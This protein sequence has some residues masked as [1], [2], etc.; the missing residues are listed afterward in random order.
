MLKNNLGYPRIGP[1]RKLKNATEKYWAGKITQKE[2]IETGSQIRVQNW[3]LQQEAGIDLIPSNDFSFYDHIL[4]MSLIT[5]NIPRRFAILFE[6]EVSELDIYFAMARGYQKDGLDIPAMEMT[7]WFNTNYHYIVPKF[8]RNQNFYLF[9]NKIIHEFEESKNILGRASKPVLIGP[10][11][12]LLL[13]KVKDKGLNRLDFLQYLLP[14]YFEILEKLVPQGLE[15]IQL[16]E[17]YLNMDLS[18]EEKAAYR[19][20]YNKFHERFPKVKFLVTT[21]FDALRENIP[22]ALSLSISALHID[23]IEAP[24]QLQEVL[25]KIPESLILSL[26]IIDGRNIWKNNYEKSVRLINKAIDKIGADRIMIAPSSSLL[27]VPVDLEGEDKLNPD[28]KSWLAFSKQKLNELSELYEIIN[29]DKDELLI[30]NQN[31]I[32]NRNSSSLVHNDFVRRKTEAAVANNLRRKS[33]FAIRQK[34]QKSQNRL[35]LFPTTTIGS[36]PQT[37][38]IRR[39]RSDLN[40]GELSSEEYARQIRNAIENAIKFQEK[41]GLDV[42]VHGEFER[43]DMVEYFGEML[44]GFA[45][46]QNGWV[47]SYG[48]RCV[49]P[50]IIY[51]DVNRTKDMTVDWI[52][53]AQPKT[54]KLVKGMLTGPVTILQWSFVRED[55]PASET[56][57]QIAAAVREEVLGLEKAGIKIIQIDEPAF[58]EGLPLRR[59]GWRDYLEW[60]VKAFHIASGAVKDETQIHTHMCYSEFNDIIESIAAMDADVI[61]IETSRSQ[62]ELLN[63][64]VNFKYPNEIGPGVYDIHSPRVPSVDEIL[65]LMEKATALLPIENLWI[66]PDCGLKTRKWAETEE[67]LKNMV[68]AARILR[69][70]FNGKY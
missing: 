35:P 63:A 39:L 26:G 28:I 67:S 4:D 54:K 16:D 1:K 40:K 13:G 58:R 20:T 46:T 59:S 48:S 52:K 25:D 47:Q 50:P 5:G 3:L 45:F 14:V 42:L 8:Y 62:M 49:K 66:N 36:F 30:E 37:T 38:E 32:R 18:D 23:L 65:M 21:Y 41:L 61:T 11:S 64:F 68:E 24:K 9:S 19:Y 44:E 51:G 43:T 57:F 17:P 70:Q 10:V 31:I 55:Q 15:W 27:H 33:E 29:H 56:A 34:K 22:L 60:A 7:K 12:Y 6:R 2:L 53:F 69:R